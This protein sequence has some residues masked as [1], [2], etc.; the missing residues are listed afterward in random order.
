MLSYPRGMPRDAK[1]ASGSNAVVLLKMEANASVRVPSVTLRGII[2]QVITG[3]ATLTRFSWGISPSQVQVVRD[4]FQD[5][6][7][8]NKKEF[9]IEY[10]C[11]S[12]ALPYDGTRRYK[13]L[14][15]QAH[16]FL[17]NVFKY[18]RL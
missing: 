3:H 5:Q 2:E 1:S 11:R 16:G 10:A 7:M 17:S 6:E 8:S 13:R 18:R 12:V 9:S 14:S 4:F 15:T